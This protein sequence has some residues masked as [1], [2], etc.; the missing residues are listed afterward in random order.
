ML[1]AVPCYGSLC[2]DYG[3]AQFNATSSCQRRCPPHVQGCSNSIC[4]PRTHRNPSLDRTNEHRHALD[5]RDDS[6]HDEAKA[7]RCPARA[8]RDIGQQTPGLLLR[9]ERGCRAQPG[10]DARVGRA[11]KLPRGVG[12]L[13]LV[14]FAEA[15]LI[16]LLSASIESADV[17]DPDTPMA[18]ESTG[19]AASP[20]DD[21][22][23]CR[24]ARQ[25]AAS[26][27]HCRSRGESGPEL[28]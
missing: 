2:R 27:R 7:R 12:E 1:A 9:R 5:L 26:A 15:R 28:G 25:A 23:R 8:T 19:P 21:N 22:Q 16:S 6:I 3:A 24:R 20:T 11:G 13:L 4:L 18:P 10:R 17:C 14:T